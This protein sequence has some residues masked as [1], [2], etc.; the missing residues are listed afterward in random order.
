MTSAASEPGRPDADEFA[1]FYAGYVAL[2]PAGDV[3]RHLRVQMHETLATLSG[4]GD[5]VGNRA[6]GA[7]KW[8]LK[9]VIG[10]MSD[11]ERVF[12]YRLLRIARADETP[13]SAFDENLWVPASCANAR[14][15][16]SL[17]LE[18]SAVRLASV[19][20]ADALPPEAWTRRGT[21]SGKTISARALAYIMAGHETHH[22][23]IIRER[24][25]SA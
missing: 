1:P 20:L 6:Y 8:T 13:L 15:V 2:V 22:L 17:L 24:Y 19:A 21:A 25:L 18:F 7:G 16:D 9:E 23:R 5:A 12:A 4:T 10:H 3:R 11:A 14:S